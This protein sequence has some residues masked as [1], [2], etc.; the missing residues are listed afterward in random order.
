MHGKEVVSLKKEKKTNNKLEAAVILLIATIFLIG[1][2]I[3]GINDKNIYIEDIVGVLGFI[4]LG[5]HMWN[6]KVHFYGLGILA[7][8]GFTSITDAIF[9]AAWLRVIIIAALTCADVIILMLKNA[10]TGH[11]KKKQIK[12]NNSR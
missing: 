11:T 10:G 12:R 9:D 6:K 4:I 1:S 7:V 3:C 2:V 5:L 8:I